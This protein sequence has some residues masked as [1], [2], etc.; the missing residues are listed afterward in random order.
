MSLSEALAAGDF[1]E[2]R[3]HRRF[4]HSMQ[5]WCG[6]KSHGEELYGS[7]R[8]EAC[9]CS[10]FD[11]DSI[12]AAS[13]LQE[14][15]FHWS[16]NELGVMESA[17]FYGY[18]ITQIPGGFLAAKFA[19]N[20]YVYLRCFYPTSQFLSILTAKRTYGSRK[21]FFQTV[22]TSNWLRV[23]FQLIPSDGFQ[24]S[25]RFFCRRNSSCSGTRAG[26]RLFLRMSMLAR[27]I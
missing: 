25:F 20:K 6:Q 1:G 16:R 18:L 10:T 21:L 22:R 24:I 19:P 12:V 4:R 23:I 8:S 26:N 27:N 7:V 11:A 5:F 14:R 2:Y 15:E 3:L 17:F 9:Q 13:V